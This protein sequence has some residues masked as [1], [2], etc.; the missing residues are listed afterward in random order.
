MNGQ[1]K[2]EARATSEHIE[3]EE[4]IMKATTSGNSFRFGGVDEIVMP[5]SAINQ[6]NLSKFLGF[7][8]NDLKDNYQHVEIGRISKLTSNLI[9]FQ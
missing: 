8:L 5:Q 9:L 1:K 2:G 3:S 7:D 6:F 4:R